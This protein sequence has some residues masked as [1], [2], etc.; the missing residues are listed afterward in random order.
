LAQELE[1][2]GVCLGRGVAHEGQFTTRGAG[3][4]AVIKALPLGGKVGHRREVYR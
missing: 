2:S 4:A 3:C 1:V